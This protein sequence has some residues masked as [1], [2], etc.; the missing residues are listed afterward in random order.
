MASMSVWDN[1]LRV[2]RYWSQDRRPSGSDFLMFKSVESKKFPVV[3]SC[4]FQRIWNAMKKDGLP[5]NEI[6]S[7]I[8]WFC[9]WLTFIERKN[10]VSEGNGKCLYYSSVTSAV[11]PCSRREWWY[12]NP[13]SSTS[14]WKGRPS[15]D[16]PSSWPEIPQWSS[17]WSKFHQSGNFE[18]QRN[19]VLA[20]LGIRHN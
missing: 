8:Q 7:H 1:E 13:F 9:V 20:G 10:Q 18:I 6:C 2:R 19:G 11:F 4:G 12:Q 5:W 17:P 14:V 3:R 15:N 16:K